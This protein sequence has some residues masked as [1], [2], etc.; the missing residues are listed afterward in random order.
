MCQ[1]FTGC[2][3][4]ARPSFYCSAQCA[5][6]LLTSAKAGNFCEW[7]AIASCTKYNRTEEKLSEKWVCVRACRFFT[8]KQACTKGNQKE[9]RFKIL[10]VCSRYLYSTTR[11]NLSPKRIESPY[12]K[13]RNSPLFVHPSFYRNFD[14]LWWQRDYGGLTATYK[15][16]PINN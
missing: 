12:T 15:T 9:G 10:N 5:K 14:T 2:T 8:N 13:W 6:S 4:R 16:K 3:D 11:D 1:H 7:T